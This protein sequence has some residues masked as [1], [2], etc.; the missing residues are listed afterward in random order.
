MVE[1]K[2]TYV[3]LTST[4]YV[5]RGFRANALQPFLRLPRLSHEI[6]SAPGPNAP[7]SFVRPGKQPDTLF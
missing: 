4:G 6:V 1:V 2:A 5:G 7:K 3:A